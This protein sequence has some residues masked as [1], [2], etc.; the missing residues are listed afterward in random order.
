MY[1]TVNSCLPG[2]TINS[3]CPTPFVVEFVSVPDKKYRG[4]FAVQQHGAAAAPSSV[5]HPHGPE[6]FRGLACIVDT[7]VQSSY[8][9]RS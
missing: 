6:P 3:C 8:A 7:D 9:P 1:S 5:M 2:G 4:F